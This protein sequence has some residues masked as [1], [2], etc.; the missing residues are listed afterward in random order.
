MNRFDG[1]KLIVVVHTSLVHT[2]YEGKFWI[3]SSTILLR[4]YS[5]RKIV[6]KFTGCL[7]FDR[8]ASLADTSDSERLFKSK[9]SLGLLC[10]VGTFWFDNRQS[11]IICFIVKVL[12]VMSGTSI[13]RV[14]HDISAFSAITVILNV[15][16]Y[17][18]FK[19]L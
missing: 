4:F 10:N 11:H 15:D 5:Q 18:R 13:V 16:K 6:Y 17:A 12:D 8:F 3:I 19:V 9:T 14:K 2:E 7:D 1:W